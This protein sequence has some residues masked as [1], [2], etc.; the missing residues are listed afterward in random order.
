MPFESPTTDSNMAVVLSSEESD[1]FTSSSLRRSHSQSKFVSGRRSQGGFQ[2]SASTS[3]IDQLF[4]ENYH[5]QPIHVVPDSSPSSGPPSPTITLRA[6][7]ES[8]PSCSSTPATSLSFDGQYEGDASI[9]FQDTLLLSEYG[10]NPYFMLD[11]L[12][13]I[14]PSL[15]SRIDDSHTVSP[16]DDA[17]TGT[18]RPGSPTPPEHAEDDTAVKHRPTQ[19]VDY[20]SHD[21][22]EEDIW[23]SWR[24]IISKRREFANAPRL[25]NASWRTWMK[26]KYGLKTVSPETLNWYACFFFS[27]LP[28][29]TLTLA[30]AKRL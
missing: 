24:Y 13:D 28:D 16:A 8:D 2:T 26:A 9:G 14:E 27:V 22:R 21:W 4:H 23:S 17:S 7:S 10:D 15:S 29:M 25:E 19:H 6:E 20:L 3:R 12:E 5:H 30:K 18:S 1:L 11:D